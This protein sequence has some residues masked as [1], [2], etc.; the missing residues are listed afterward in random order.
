MLSQMAL[1]SWF[2]KATNFLGLSPTSNKPELL[3]G[4]IIYCKNNVCVH[5]PASLS[6]DCGHVPG[7]LTVRSQ[8]DEV[9]IS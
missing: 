5:P 4:D 9:I 8:K 2:K 7:Y 6:H 1:S 3:D